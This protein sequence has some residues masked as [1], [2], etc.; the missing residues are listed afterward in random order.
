MALLAK[1]DPE[2]QRIKLY[3]EEWAVELCLTDPQAQSLS[4]S[5]ARAVMDARASQKAEEGPWKP[6][7]A[8]CP[9]KRTFPSE[10]SAKLHNAKA[11]WR[12]RTYWCEPCSGWHVTNADKTP[13]NRLPRTE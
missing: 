5:L 10:Q 12:V 2:D 3:V 6:P 1:F 4:V 8:D 11:G 9:G 7:V 13:K